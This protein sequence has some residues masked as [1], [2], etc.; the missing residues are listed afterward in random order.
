MIRIV[1]IGGVPATGKSTLMLAIIKRFSEEPKQLHWGKLVRGLIFQNNKA[2]VLGF[3][4]KGES[5]GGTDRLSL[6]VQPEVFKFLEGCNVGNSMNG[7]T[8]YFEG[9]RLFN[10]SFLEQIG[11]MNIQSLLIMLHTEKSV[12]RA[13]HLKRK[14]NQNETW[15]KGRETKYAR[16]EKNPKIFH[17][18]HD[19]S[20]DTENIVDAILTGKVI[21]DNI[22]ARFTRQEKSGI[23]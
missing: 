12:L 5:F 7:Y 22:F 4:D 1:A 19:T 11:K 14:D 23:I 17:W 21:G 20:Q 18:N 8:I 3:Y 2:I 10:L 6:A 16:M 9:D 15:L 13:R